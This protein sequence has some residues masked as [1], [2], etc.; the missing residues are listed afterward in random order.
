MKNKNK[1]KL[2][3]VTTLDE[4]RE[5]LDGIK[6]SAVKEIQLYPL[7]KIIDF[8]GA[9]QV[10]TTG[11]AVRFTHPTLKNNP[12]YHGYFAVH[13]IHK[14]GDK[15]EIKMVDFKSYLYPALITIINEKKANPK[16]K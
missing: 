12:Y 3:D 16:I 15:D 13:K 4:V 14:G 1:I 10:P 2:N 5:Y 9:T 8:L 7:L 6:S 11:S